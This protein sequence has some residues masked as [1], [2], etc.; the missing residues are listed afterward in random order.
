MTSTACRIGD[1]S[2]Q[3][4]TA[5]EEELERYRAALGTWQTFQPGLWTLGYRSTEAAAAS[6]ELEQPRAQVPVNLGTGG[7]RTGWYLRIGDRLHVRYAFT[8]GQRPW[9][10]GPGRV[11]TE[12]PPGM[13]G[14]A[15]ASQYVHCHLWTTSGTEGTMDFWGSALVHPGSR[16][17]VQPM[18]PF[19]AADCRL[20]F[21]TIAGPTAGQRAWSV[22]YI[23][24]GFPEGGILAIQG[25]LDIS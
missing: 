3:R 24:T 17:F 5:L 20:G 9:D 10:A 23:A 8:W 11:V 21:Y 2:S 4:V 14:E 12:M 25:T 6:S 1:R 7:T 13:L 18:F 19:S 22:P 16:G 15:S